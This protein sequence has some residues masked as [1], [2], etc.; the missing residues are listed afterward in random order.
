MRNLKSVVNSSKTSSKLQYDRAIHRV[1]APP[2]SLFVNRTLDQLWVRG[3]WAFR[4]AQFKIFYKDEG[5][6]FLLFPRDPTSSS[7]RPYGF[8][9]KV[10]KIH[11]AFYDLCMFIFLRLLKKL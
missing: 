9:V 1:F 5:L 4:H 11:L 3:Y 10:I 8:V 2:K 7:K 6:F